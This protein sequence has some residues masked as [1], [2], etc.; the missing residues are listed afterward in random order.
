[1]VEVTG[2]P[3]GG[4]PLLTRREF[5]GG[6]VKLAVV[7]ALVPG[8]LSQVLPAVAPRGLGGGG[9]GP[10]ILRDPNTN[11][12]IPVTLDMLGGEPP[13][14]LTA[15]WNFLPAVVY[16]VRRAT[17]EGSAERRG[18]NTGQYALQHPTE[19]DHAILL[20]EG[21]CKHLGCTVGWDGSLPASA[22]VADYN[23]DGVN[24]GRILCPCHQG[25]YDIFDLAL[26]VPGT[27]PPAPLNVI[28]F[29]VKRFDDEETGTS[30]ENVVMGEARVDQN[31]PRAA[32]GQTP[33][34][35]DGFLLRNPGWSA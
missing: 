3:E 2:Q 4:P 10:V 13:V 14:V 23:D 17:L 1:M 24:D 28:V 21:K 33:F 29:D 8:V 16:K 11:A 9:A 26:N 22:D 12:K 31:G 32:S 35:A 7:G 5:I 25:Q 30:T 27:P 20:Y 18:Y 19:P 34:P 6:V 15:E